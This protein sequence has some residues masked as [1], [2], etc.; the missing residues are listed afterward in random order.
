[1][2]LAV[3]VGNTNITLG[4]F[5]DANLKHHWRMETARARTA[6]EFGI[7]F[8]QLFDLVKV[9]FRIIKGIA[10]SNVVPQLQHILLTT[11]QRY[12][13]REPLWVTPKTAK[14]PLRVDHP[15]E[16]G[17]DR[18][19][20]AV[21]AWEKFKQ[22][23]IVVDFGTATTLD[24][25]TAKGEYGG[26][27]IAPGIG[28]ANLALTKAAAKLPRVE[29][30]KPKRVVG[31]NTVECIQA[32]L[33]YGYVGLVDHLIELSIKEEGVPMKVVATGGLAS[34]IAKESK[35]IEKVE[36]FLTLEGLYFIWKKNS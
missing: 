32:G 19:C 34:L 28:I 30:D 25:V 7:L 13:D 2:L 10:I 35:K 8:K 24:I 16:V 4:L 18:L 3:D 27:A 9:D 33:Y 31:R 1:M 14:I 11:C 29:I 6:D 21:A 15:E 20:N 23:T 26:G 22:A 5:E 36:R 17:A 12:F